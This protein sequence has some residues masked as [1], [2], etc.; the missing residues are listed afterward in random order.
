[1]SQNIEQIGH[2]M[3]AEWVLKGSVSLEEWL[4]RFPDSRDAVL[5]LALLIEAPGSIALEGVN[6]EWQDDRGVAGRA[7]ERLVAK[8][9]E[10]AFQEHER[11]LAASLPGART[12][13]ARARSKGRA[14]APFR[15]AS[16]LTWVLDQVRGESDQASRYVTHKTVYLLEHALELRL[17]TGFKKMA[18]G[19]YD[20]S[21][22]YKDAEP[23]AE[24]NGWLRR[25]NE[26]LVATRS[27]RA[28]HRYAV[29]YLGDP[30][31]ARRFVL[32]VARLE[33]WELDTLATVHSAACELYNKRSEVDELGV[34]RLLSDSAEWKQKLMKRHFARERISAALDHLRRLGLLRV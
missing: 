1:M 6:L 11:E 21:L 20:P 26:N 15:R 3:L 2:A 19:P 4:A 13:A 12:A 7:R 5:Q 28:A 32:L 8:C 30:E 33:P 24:R 22:R 9:R 29:R 27:S 25:E 14:K 34:E 31:L 17:F 10:L 18:A 23:I 16:I